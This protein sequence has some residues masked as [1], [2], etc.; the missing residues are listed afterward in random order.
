MPANLR[1]TAEWLTKDE[2][3]T[4]NDL[5][6]SL[7]LRLMLRPTVSRPVCLGIKHPSGTNG[8]IFITVRQLRVYWWG[9]P[10][11]ERTGLSF[12][13]AAGPRQ[14]SHSRARVPWDS[15][16]FYCLRFET[17][18]FVTSY[19]SQ[20]YGGAIRPRLHTLESIA[21]PPFITSRRTECKSLNGTRTRWQLEQHY[22]CF[23]REKENIGYE[24]YL[25]SYGLFN[26]D[27]SRWFYIA[28]SE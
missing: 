2:W 17:S 12:T 27:P 18:L 9:A 1:M 25:I 15:R 26:D 21:C 10:S 6:L 22:Y 13:I 11:Y 19:D 5:N 16:P 8:Q 14:R 7:S 23:L 3:R 24:S 20:G 4:K 28:S